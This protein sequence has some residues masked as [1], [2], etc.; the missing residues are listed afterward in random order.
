MTGTATDIEVT[1][2]R[3]RGW[4]PGVLAALALAWLAVVLWSAHATISGTRA[5][6]TVALASAA[7]ALPLVVAASLVAGAAVGIASSDLLGRRYGAVAERVPVRFAASAG[8]GLAVGLLCAVLVLAG[9]GTS[10]AIAVLAA[11]VGAAATLGGVLGG[12]RPAAVVG[13]ALGGTLAWFVVGLFQGAY[14]GRL[15]HLFGAG[16]TLASQVRATSWLSFVVSVV[17]GLVAGLSA[18]GYL[19]RRDTGLRWPAYL[20]AGAGPG[21]LILLS[22]LV[23]RVGG[24]RLLAVAGSVGADDRAAIGYLGTARLNTALVVLFVGALTTVIAFGRTL[25]PA[26]PT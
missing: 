8:G 25:K 24:A 22:D 10:A 19:R 18:Y 2:E 17:G 7:L 26:G 16:D 14:A 9:Y 1:E 20:A 15:M 6:A 23:T 3:T 13:A 5:D 11:A 4:G 21:L 12:L